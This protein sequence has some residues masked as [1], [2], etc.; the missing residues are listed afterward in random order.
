M[1]V[2]PGARLGSYE[3]LSPLGAGGMG[4]VYR[5]RDTKLNRDVAL[6]TLPEHLAVDAER[7][8]RFER[9]A[10][11]IAALNHPNIVTI[12]SVEEAGGVLFLTMELVEGRPLDAL[13]VKGGMPF[14]RI[15]ALAIPL[16]DA[17]SAAH[18]KG[19]THRDLKPAN[20]MVTAD[21]RVKVLD[22]GL[23]KL[24]EPAP[25]AAGASALPTRALTGDGRIV[26]T[27]AYMSPEQAE[28]KPVDHRS[29]I[30]SLGVMLYELATGARPFTGETPVSTMT[31]ILRDTPRSIA[32]INAG[33]P[34]DLA[35]IVRRCL[36]KDPEQRTH[37]AKDLRNQLEDLRHAMDSGELLAV[38]AT[39][40]A[41]GRSRAAAIVAATSLI[42][43]IAAVAVV[44]YLRPPV[45]APLVTKLDAVTP[46]T[47]DPFSFALSPDGRQL[48]FVASEGVSRLWVRPLDQATA[49]PLAGTE[50]AS[51]PFWKPDGRAIGFFADGKLKRIDVAVGAPQVLADAQGARG[52]TWNQDDVIV[53]GPQASGLMRIAATATRGKPTAVTT[54][55]PGQFSHRWPQFLPDG[56]R[57]LFLAAL[58]QSETRGI[59][60]GSLDGGEP[61][62]LLAGETA[63]M[64]VPPGYLLRVQQGVLVAHPFDVQRGVVSGEQVPLAQ[65]VGLDDGTLHSAFSASDTGVLAHRPGTLPRRQLVWVDRTGEVTG[66]VKAPDDKSLASP[67]LAPDER[68]VAVSRGVQGNFDVWLAEVGRAFETKLTFDPNIDQGSVWSPDGSRLVFQSNRTGV[69]ELF[70][71]PVNKTAADRP[72]AMATPD[73][74][75]KSVVDWSRDGRFLLYAA[76]DPKAGTDETD[77]WA[78]P[79]TGD[80][81]PFPVVQTRFQERNG[82]FSP[83]G[84]WIAYVSNETGSDEVY[85]QPFPGPG[86]KIQVSNSGGT[87]PRWR[88]DGR[89]LFFVAADGKLMAVPIEITADGQTLNPGAPMALFQTRLATGGNIAIGWLTRPQYAVASDGRFLMNVAVDTPVEPITI[90]LNWDA[91]LKK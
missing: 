77:L 54:L 76:H 39:T 41:P 52:G 88:R 83:D 80:G 26:G 42:V 90:V 15:L 2:Q 7:R 63:A 21:G 44:L 75:D 60:L 55:A 71:K 51:Y 70:E 13:L 84:R 8:L 5:A 34:R 31:S 18:D 59:Y 64:Y 66:V 57:L 10:Q 22:F 27:V 24:V 50:G 43:A 33:M 61:T 62:R 9:E 49:R 6:K 12:H 58:G 23:A 48:A 82:Q 20:V 79:L 45:P 3:I 47:S 36:A 29:D 28:G 73:K 56:R 11:S 14:S 37:S 69:W 81:K 74:Q 40:R 78:L 4:E 86:G 68:R 19:I 16:A 85:I 72:L 53:F 91:G 38:P 30:F 89:E 1:S 65:P 32:E 25:A 35:V 46:P 87:D 17:V 67:Q